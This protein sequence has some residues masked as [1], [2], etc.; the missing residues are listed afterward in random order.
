[1]E[2][3]LLNSNG[4]EGAVV[5]ASDVVFG[6]DYNEALIHQSSSL[7]SERSPGQSRA[8]GSRASQ[9]HDEE[10]VAPEG[11]G[12]RSCRY[13][14]E[15]V[16]AWRWS[17]FPELARRKLLAQGQQEDASRR[18]LLDLLAAGPRRPSVGRRGHRSR[19]A[20]D[21]AAGRQ[22]QGH[23]SRFR[24]RHHR[25]GRRK[26]VPRVAQPAPRGGCRAALR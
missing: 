24:A 14:V 18:S 8:E 6:R 11:Y 16:V 5:N 7:I 3:K 13:V 2:L 26:P 25:H 9:A 17:D 19:S 22:V 10:A 4:Q 12:P 21:Q 23:G 15:P 20:E 1:M